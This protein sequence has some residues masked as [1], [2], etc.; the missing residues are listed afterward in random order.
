MS[1]L[2]QKLGIK[3]GFR[4]R[5]IGAPDNAAQQIREAC[6]PGTEIL[7]DLPKERCELILFWPT[8]RSE[9]E[10]DFRRLQTHITPDG[11][12]WAVIPKKQFAQPRGIDFSWEELQAAGLRT[13]LVDNKVASIN[14][15][16]YGTRFVIRKVLRS[17]YE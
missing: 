6:P 3:P 17:R 14:G 1:S 2:A 12:V 11:A 13:D 8:R 9:L 5:L 10:E 15:E 7:A 4:I 16:E